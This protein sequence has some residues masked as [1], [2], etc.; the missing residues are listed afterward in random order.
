MEALANALSV[1][2]HK[3]QATV[4]SDRVHILNLIINDGRDLD[5]PQDNPPKDHPRFSQTNT[6]FQRRVEELAFNVAL[7]QGGEAWERLLSVL[8]NRLGMLIKGMEPHPHP[9]GPHPHPMGPQ[10]RP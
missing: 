4:E 10:L 9:M 1:Q 7:A 5:S 2:L 8:S 6:L 3:G